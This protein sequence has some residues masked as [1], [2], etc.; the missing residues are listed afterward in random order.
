MSWVLKVLGMVFRIE[1]KDM[2]AAVTEGLFLMCI[3][4]DFMVCV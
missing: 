1:F 2:E 3:R 4:R